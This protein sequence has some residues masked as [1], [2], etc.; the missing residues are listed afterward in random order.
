M[1]HEWI[2]VLNNTEII[3]WKV[4]NELETKSGYTAQNTYWKILEDS[5]FKREVKILGI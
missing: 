4:I 1:W 2:K 5:K 3:W